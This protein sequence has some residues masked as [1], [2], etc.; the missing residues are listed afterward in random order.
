MFNTTAFTDGGWLLFTLSCLLGFVSLYIILFYLSYC[1]LATG[2]TNS[3]IAFYIMPIF[4]AL[5]MFRQTLPNWLSDKTGLLNVLIPYALICGALILCMQAV[6]SLAVS[7]FN[8]RFQIPSRVAVRELTLCTFQGYVL[9]AIFFGF[10]SGAFITLPTVVYIIL[11]E[12][13]SR[14]GTRIGMGFAL[15]GLG[16]LVG[17]PGGGAVLGPDHDWTSTWVFGGVMLLASGVTLTVLRVWRYGAK[18]NTKA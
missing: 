3:S 1:R 14:I 16:I 6:H 5:S 7:T 9:I 8:S 2:T 15:L 4:N 17:G 11:T 18:L 10:F 12:D 13:K